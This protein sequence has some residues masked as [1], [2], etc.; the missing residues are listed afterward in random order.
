MK[1]DYSSAVILPAPPARGRASRMAIGLLLVITGLLL[2]L[3]VLGWWYLARM[4]ARYSRVAAE[5]AASLNGLHEVGLHSFTGYGNI[6]QLRQTQD[7]GAR[8]ALLHTVAE[9]RAAN[10]RVFEK[11]KRTL[12]DPELSGCLQD[13]IAKRQVCRN[14]ADAFIAEAG[15]TA[16]IVPD[17]DRS[18]K[19]LQ[20]FVTYQQS[21]DL[22]TD[23]IESASLQA[24][25]EMSGEIKHLR[26][27][28]LGVGVLP[29]A[30]ALVFLVLTLSLL[31]VVKIDG[32]EE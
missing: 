3:G 11:L 30:S 25:R 17:T 15:N 26:W 24:C 10:D 8:A 19:L 14:E 23:R 22:L 13:V 6:I 9:E 4:D 16:S 1:N 5:A 29:I 20:S 27:L 7:P 18:L 32:E 28:F 31:Q 21:C 2:A 12:T